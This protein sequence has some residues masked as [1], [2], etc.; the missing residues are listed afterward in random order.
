MQTKQLVYLSPIRR[1]LPLLLA[2]AILGLL[3]FAAVSSAATRSARAANPP[4]PNG[5]FYGDGDNTTYWEYATSENGSKLYVYYDDPVLY[6]AMVVDRTVNDNVFSPNATYRGSAGWNPPHT[7]TGLTNSE[8]ASFTLE[9]TTAPQSWSWQQGYAAKVGDNWV[10]NHLI[11]AG[12]G[13]PPPTYTSGSSFAWNLNTYEDAVTP[14]EWDMYV[15]GSGMGDWTSPYDP[16]PTSPVPGL[17]GYPV[18]GPITYSSFFEFEWPMVYEW[19]VDLDTAGCGDNPVYVIAGLSHHSPSKNGDEND[20]F[21]DCEGEDCFLKDWGDLPDTYSTLSA[22]GGPSHRF[23]VG[24]PH[25][26]PLTDPESDGQPNPSATGDDITNDNDDDGVARIVGQQWTPGASVDVDFDVICSVGGSAL[27]GVWMDWD[28]DGA[29][30]ADEFYSFNALC[31][32]THTE[33]FTVPNDYVTGTTLAVRIRI[34][35]SSSDAPGGSLDSGDFGGIAL[36]GE[37]EDYL[38][39]F[40]P[41]AIT[42]E[43]ISAVSAG[44]LHPAILLGILLLL[45]GAG[46][47][48]L[49]KGRQQLG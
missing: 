40:T 3:A 29:F 23:V 2:A 18:T 24:G 41:T 20:E 19:S 39:E 4:I 48:L 44:G 12:S 21:P 42:L 43:Q 10:S 47:Y 28:N 25:L 30:Q 32:A 5:I 35:G 8:F 1:F 27:I 49:R 46:F 13:T 17:E 33:T 9:C 45:G 6:V 37:V 38:W 34:F 26:G 22:S 7:A 11:G 16:D 36:N 14:R 15:H 31:N